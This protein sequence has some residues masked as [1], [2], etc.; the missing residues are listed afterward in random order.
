MVDLPDN[1]EL[2]ERS[3]FEGF[4]HQSLNYGAACSRSDNILFLDADTIVPPKYDLLINDALNHNT[5]GG[6]FEF[7]FRE[8][9][10]ILKIIEICNRI[11]YRV[12]NSYY[13]DQGFFVSK[14][15][16][17][18][19]GGFP[20]VPIMETAKLCRRLNKIGRLKLIKTP[21]T[22]SARRF[23]RGGILKV[24]AFDIIIWVRAFLGLDIDKYAR[25][26]WRENLVKYY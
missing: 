4:K 8:R 26:Y 6:A 18:S 25:G 11:R 10:P 1:V 22:T 9:H 7:A 21:I 15:A 2:Y 5:V 14:H 19:M 17:E 24:F 13:G 23:I 3:E 20:S 16:F 12:R